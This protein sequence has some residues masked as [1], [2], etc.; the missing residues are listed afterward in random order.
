MARIKF[1]HGRLIEGANFKKRRCRGV[2]CLRDIA[3]VFWFGGRAWHSKKVAL[4]AR[5][6]QR[7]SLGDLYAWPR[8][9]LTPAAG[10]VSFY[11]ETMAHYLVVS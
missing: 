5:Y 1:A 10:L 7:G 2:Q 4:G 6:V 9:R 3:F 11:V 8:A